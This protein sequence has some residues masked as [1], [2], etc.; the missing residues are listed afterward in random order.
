MVNAK[1]H[2]E[3]CIDTYLAPAFP[4]T[5]RRTRIVFFLLMQFPAELATEVEVVL[6]L[7]IKKPV[8][9]E[10]EAGETRPGW[11]TVLAMEVMRGCVFLFLS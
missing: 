8:S 4:L 10:A 1:H 6:T 11:M 5:L 3:K 9:G 2:S 7:L